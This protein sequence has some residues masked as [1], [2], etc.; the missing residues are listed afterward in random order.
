MSSSNI[1]VVVV[2]GLRASALGAYGNTSYGTPNLDQLAAESLLFDACFAPS[3]DLAAIYRALWHAE[4]PL[5]HGPPAPNAQSLAARFNERGFATTLISDDPQLISLP[6]GA[7]FQSHVTVEDKLNSADS[8]PLPYRVFDAA[9]DTIG[10]VADLSL[11]QFVW[12]HARGM[13]GSWQAPISL[14]ESLLDEEDPPPVE[15]TTP[16]DFEITDAD[17]PDTAFRYGCAYAAQVMLLD[18]CWH[19]LWTAVERTWPAGGWLVVLIGARGFPLGEHKRLGGV[20]PRLHVEQLHVP[21]LIRFPDGRGRLSRRR[22]LVSHLDIYPTLMDWLQVDTKM[23][24][25]RMATSQ[26]SAIAGRSVLPLVEHAN[27]AWRELLVSAQGTARSVRTDEWTLRW[28]LPAGGLADDAGRAELYVR[29]DDRW[30]ANDVATR[31]PDV[32]ARLSEA[33]HVQ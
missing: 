25:D 3:A 24:L 19:G 31:C 13:Y 21:W 14:Q 28:D 18:D 9:A 16:P 32:V 27:A 7:D 23:T 20:D 30:E 33:S 12:L 10:R 17:D 26:S 6:G 2:D 8:L 1:V 4:H 11:P 29:P 5:R 22:Q 15:E